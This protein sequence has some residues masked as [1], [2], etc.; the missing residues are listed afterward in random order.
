MDSIYRCSNCYRR[1]KA[2]AIAINKRKR[3]PNCGTEH[4][5][6]LMLQSFTEDFEVDQRFDTIG[7]DDTINDSDDI[8][9][10]VSFLKSL[11]DITPNHMKKDNLDKEETVYYKS[12]N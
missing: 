10:I 11:P 4:I 12:F 2:Q 1:L 5:V 9:D 8:T 7:L 3:C 6:P